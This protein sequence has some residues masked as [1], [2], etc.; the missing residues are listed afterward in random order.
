MFYAL[1][2]LALGFLWFHQALKAPFL[3]LSLLL[4][5]AG[6]CFSLIGLGFLLSKLQ[7][8]GSRWA[9]VIFGKRKS[10]KRAF[11]AL[12]VHWPFLLV[13]NAIFWLHWFSKE[14]WC[15][16]V[17][18]NVFL[19]R[20][21]TWKDK[22]RLKALSI[23]GV[24]D[25]TAEFAAESYVRELDYH[26]LPTFDETPPS[27]EALKEVANWI[28]SRQEKGPLLIHC[29]RG[30]GRSAT[31]VAAWLLLTGRCS[32]V[33]EAE[34]LMQKGRP[35]VRMSKWQKELLEDLL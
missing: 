25:L 22:E 3:W 28:E 33:A 23:E 1:T 5:N 16:E 2:F 17:L 13:N 18:P 32:T 35:R 30:H 7:G 29:A 11:W 21:P 12:C 19:G 31:V 8:N 14:N 15:D 4:S 9:T 27:V 10:G 34:E 20:F 6:L 24:V 26:A